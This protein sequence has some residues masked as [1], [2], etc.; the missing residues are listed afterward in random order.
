M[1]ASADGHTQTNT[2]CDRDADHGAGGADDDATSVADAAAHGYA[3]RCADGNSP[4]ATHT[5]PGGAGAY[6]GA[7]G[8]RGTVAY[9]GT[10]GCSSTGGNASG[11]RDT[12]ANTRPGD[13][14][15]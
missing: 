4:C 8:H 5:D 7:N 15:N 2:Y 12:G 1:D 6:S 13:C 3:Y 11:C 14:S 9:T 10:D